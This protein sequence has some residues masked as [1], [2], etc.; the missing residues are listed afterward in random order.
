MVARTAIGEQH[1]VIGDVSPREPPMTLMVAWG[2]WVGRAGLAFL[3]LLASFSIVVALNK[4]A[5]RS[6]IASSA[7]AGPEAEFRAQV[8]VLAPAWRVA[9]ALLARL[10]RPAVDGSGRAIAGQ[11]AGRIR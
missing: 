4:R 2:D 11:R 10:R 6:A 7:A 8:V 1:V 9:A 3:L 5:A